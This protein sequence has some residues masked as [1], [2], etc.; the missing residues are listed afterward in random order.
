MFKD[1]LFKPVKM[2][3]T[4]SAQAKDFLSK[5]LVVDV[6]NLNVYILIIKATQRLGYSKKDAEELKE[7]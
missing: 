5:L 3:T 1:I 2:K 6:I 7:H 4:F